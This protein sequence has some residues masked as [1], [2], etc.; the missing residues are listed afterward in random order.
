[1]PA[2][3]EHPDL[4]KVIV[5]LRSASRSF[6]AR[7]KEGKVHI[8]APMAASSKDILRA[9]DTLAPRLLLVRPS[10][11]R[12]L[13]GNVISLDSLEIRILADPADS[14][15]RIRLSSVR[16]SAL[17]GG[18]FVLTFYIGSGIDTASDSYPSLMS[19]SIAKAIGPVAAEVL[20]P[21]ARYHA[22]RVGDSPSLWRIGRGM[23]ILGTCTSDRVITLSRAIMFLPRELRDYVICHELAHLREM[24]HSE[25]FHVLLESY[26]PGASGL[27]A[28]LRRFE[29]PVLR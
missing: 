13:P 25:H 8:S 29:W 2:L 7:W 17:N 23:R 27:A 12:L 22:R 5:T 9:I 24:N 4:G 10:M 21:L 14:A 11:S 20:I 1:M 15:R 3:I 16:P 28:R 6:K 19:R 18:K 26:L